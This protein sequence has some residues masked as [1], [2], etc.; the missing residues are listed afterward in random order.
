MAED[1][2]VQARPLAELRRGEPRRQVLERLEGGVDGERD[3]ER[4]GPGPE[5]VVVGVAVRFLAVGEGRHEPAL[6]SVLDRS[7]EL[8][9]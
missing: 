2:E 9:G 3:T 6:A 7:F 8:V 5:R 4:L 1:A